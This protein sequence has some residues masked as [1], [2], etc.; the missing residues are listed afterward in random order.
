MPEVDA[1]Y[2]RRKAD[3]CR[4]EAAK[5]FGKE[6]ENWDRIAAEWLLLA[7]ERERTK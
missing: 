1:E 7:Y 4:E 2:C 6:Q 3:E 5:A